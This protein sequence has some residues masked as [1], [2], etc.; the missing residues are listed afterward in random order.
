M[1]TE[2]QQKSLDDAVSD[3]IDELSKLMRKGLRNKNKFVDEVVEITRKLVSQLQVLELVRMGLNTNEIAKK[4]GAHK[5]TVPRWR[6]A[7]NAPKPE[8]AVKLEKLYHR[9]RLNTKKSV[10]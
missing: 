9:R 7:D 3:A 10:S 1:S 4:V 5:T 8:Y 6:E 2:E